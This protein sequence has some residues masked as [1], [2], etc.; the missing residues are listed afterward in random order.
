MY[1]DFN[2]LIYCLDSRK[3]FVLCLACISCCV[4]VEMSGDRNWLYRMG[5]TEYILPEDGDRIQSTKHC[6]F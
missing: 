3:W 5:P 1:R 4:L 6:V 2:V